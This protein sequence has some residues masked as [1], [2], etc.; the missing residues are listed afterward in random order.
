MGTVS[1]L[2]GLLTVWGGRAVRDV[3]VKTHRKEN[4]VTFEETLV[5]LCS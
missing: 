3:F 2:V 4:C 5:L 1:A